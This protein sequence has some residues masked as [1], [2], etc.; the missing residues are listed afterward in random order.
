MDDCRRA[1][2]PLEPGVKLFK[3]MCPR[4]EREEKEMGTVPYRK[5]VGSLM[6]LGLCMRPD[7]LFAVTKFSQFNVN[8][9]REH[10]N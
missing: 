4:N 10:W 1:K 8:P 9:G 7:I 2:T 6:H 3:N 5:A